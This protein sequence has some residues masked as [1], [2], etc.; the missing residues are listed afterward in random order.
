MTGCTVL[1]V[2]DAVDLR[3][4]IAL[5]LRRDGHEVVEAASAAEALDAADAGPLDVALVDVR[6]RGDDGISLVR[7]LRTRADDPPPRV[8]LLTAAPSIDAEVVR[9]LDVHAVLAKPITIE[10]LRAVMPS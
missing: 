3:G 4:L 7:H 8:V 10:A 2:D 5:V 1:L 9:E 6:L